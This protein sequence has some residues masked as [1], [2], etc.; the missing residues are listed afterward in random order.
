MDHLKGLYAFSGI[1]FCAF[2]GR[3]ATRKDWSSTLKDKK[4]WCCTTV[5]KQ[6]RKDCN[7]GKKYSRRNARKMLF[8]C[9]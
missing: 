6:G 8:R 5:V 2:C 9:F 7:Y 4:A 3:P 1:T